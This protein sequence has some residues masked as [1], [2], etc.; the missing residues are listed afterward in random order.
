MT[1]LEKIRQYVSRTPEDPVVYH[2]AVSIFKQ[3]I[4]SGN[5]AYH[6]VNKE[7][8]KEIGR[9][10]RS[11]RMN[12]RDM[13]KLNGTYRK[14][15]LIDARVDFDAYC[16]YIEA[17]REPERQFYLPRRKVL[18]KVAGDLQK[19]E[20][21]ELDLLTISLPPGVGKALAN[22]VP[23]LT[24]HGWK[25]H[26]D[27]VV[28]DEVIG[29]NG[30]FK[31]VIAVHPKCTV[32]C[33]VEFS[34]GEKIVCHENHEWFVHDRA[35]LDKQ[36]KNYVASTKRLE[37]RA[38][39]SGA[40]AGKRGHRYT[41]QLPHRAYVAGCEKELPLDPYT[42][43]VWLGD[44][45]NK[46]PSICCSKDDRCV[47]DR[48]I[49]NGEHARW[50]TVH[51]A[52]GVLYYGFGF[53]DKL[54]KMG[55]CHSRR[56]VPKYIPEEYMTASIGQ[57]LQLLA[58]LLDTDGC[59]IG[60]KY[61]F[62]TAEPTLRDTF[63]DLVSTFGWRT[64]VQTKQPVR[65]S[66]GITAR[67]EHYVIGFTPDIEIPCEIERKRNK[68][69]HQ[70]RAIG[71]KSI[72]RVNPTEGNC[73]TVEGDGSYLVGKA[74]V[75]THNSTLAIFF[76]TWLGG[77]HPDKAVLT[78]SHDA[79]IVRGFYDEVL[80]II[81]KNGEYLYRDV[82]P[83]TE[84]PL[85]GTN[86]KELRIDLGKNKRFETF[87]FSS[88][89]SE[90]AGKYRAS[91]LL[92]CDDL[93]GGI[94]EALSK[95]R[96]DKLWRIYTTDLRQ[97]TS[98]DP[99]ELIIATRWSVWDVIGRLK[100]Q[101]QDHPSE[102][103]KFIDIP[104]L[105]EKDESNFDYPMTS[106][107]FTT[108]RYW[109]LRDSMDNTDWRAL[110]MNE[111][112]EREGQLYHPDELRR[113]FELPERQPDGIVAICDT[114][115]KG[116]DYCFM[117]ITYVYGNDWYIPDCVCDNGDPGMIEERL[118][119]M[120]IKH[121]VK[122]CQFESNSAGWKI[123][124]NVQEKI[125]VRGGTTKIITKPT[126]ANK[127]TKIVLNAPAVKDHCLFLDSSKYKPNSDYG[128]MMSML[129]TYTMMGRNKHDDV[130]DGLAILVLYMD[131]K[132]MAKAQVFARPF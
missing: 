78:F 22:N 31:K 98:G 60:S 42:F 49:R 52:T 5:T 87:Q 129:T 86:A 58:G 66:S 2:D 100:Q 74:M 104:A 91:Q 113:F 89:K 25:N 37:K 36:K 34:N 99:P 126:T 33:L 19:L 119:S 70:Q 41:V 120:L 72:T 45:V 79:G 18:G 93:C 101:Y 124:E 40:E 114:K 80:R 122:E 57:R 81:G 95:E 76:I 12:A 15:L 44:G 67:K 97:R 27:L 56:T 102:R 121:N 116:S 17:D 75:P 123:A 132:V 112:I 82:F 118:V 16:L 20:T 8:R 88:T 4:D 59:L 73:I 94:E 55:L 63:I 64:C 35:R 47:I 117:P 130:P 111:P 83:E 46:N 61:Q 65:S 26:G 1:E 85:V 96:M 62:T 43:G 11:G 108:Q 107:R 51:K 10:L 13:E 68:E 84:S 21:R 127:E 14:S 39:N 3:E 77:L 115:A 38:L 110:Y 92:Y 109:N 24:K 32:D 23:V 71:F 103:A 90:N 50:S 131:S 7:F 6:A 29:M 28:G 9:E 48:I 53:R 128:K 105:N 69:P 106:D 30:R 54:Q 125:R